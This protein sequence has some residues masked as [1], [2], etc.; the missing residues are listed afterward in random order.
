MIGLLSK[1][2]VQT[3]AGILIVDTNRRIVSLNRR[4]IEMW[5]LPQDIIVSQN[6]EEVW[7]AAANLV[8]D[9]HKFVTRVQK[10]YINT[11]L[12]FYDII[13]LQ[14]GRIFKCHSLP[15]YLESNYIGRMW[16]FS[17]V[18]ATVKG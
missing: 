10:I 13:T 2:E 7:E 15:Q 5:N 1:S 3:I 12:E 6:E 14:D 16:K 9:T 4:F 8:T 11:G 18:T 17:D